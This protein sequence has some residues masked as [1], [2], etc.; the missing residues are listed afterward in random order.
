MQ[1]CSYCNIYIVSPVPNIANQPQRL[2]YIYR[3]YS[4]TNQANDKT[5][6][7][8]NFHD[9][10]DLPNTVVYSCI[11]AERADMNENYDDIIFCRT[12]ISHG[13]LMS[14]VKDYK[15]KT[16]QKIIIC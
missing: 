6:Q 8:P 4:V 10:V 12:Y 5:E 15:H 14:R 3:P 9:T 11:N 16:Q 7:E 13:Y 2:V 1:R